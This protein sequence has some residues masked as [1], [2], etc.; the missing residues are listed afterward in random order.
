MTALKITHVIG[1]LDVGGAEKMLLKLV[2]EHD[3]VGILTE[4]ISLGDLGKVG[5]ELRTAGI[6]VHTVGARGRRLPR[7]KEVLRLLK[8]T[9][10]FSP[11]IIQGWMYHG[12]IAALFVR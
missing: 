9:K 3:K 11:D 7:I 4:I 2:R 8:I 6:V 1:G 10:T 5:N 12:N